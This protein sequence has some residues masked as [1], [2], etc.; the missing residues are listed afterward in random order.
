M[1]TRL[2]SALALTLLSFAVAQSA[3]TLQVHQGETTVVETGSLVSSLTITQDAPGITV[4]MG[5]LQVNFVTSAQAR[6]GA[7]SCV[8]VTTEHGKY[9][10]CAEVAGAGVQGLRL[11]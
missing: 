1:K 7:R 2:L 6:P 5:E 10:L 9:D 8:R 11:P 3:P 4:Q